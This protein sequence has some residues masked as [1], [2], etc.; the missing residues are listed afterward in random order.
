MK[1]I[2]SDEQLPDTITKTLFLAGPSIRDYKETD[3]RKNAISILEELKYD[4]IVFIPIPSPVFYGKTPLSKSSYDNQIKWEQNARRMSDVILFW[5]LR[6]L[7]KKAYGLT[8]NFELGEDLNTGKVTYGR[9][10]N[11]DKCRYTDTC[12]TEK[13]LPI[14]QC[15]N[16]LIKYSLTFLFN[17]KRE[18]GE[19][20][21]QSSL[22]KNHNFVNWLQLNKKVGNYLEDAKVITVFP[23]IL[24]IDIFSYIIQVNVFIKNENRY[25]SN[26]IILS[27]KDLTSVLPY[28]KKDGQTYIVLVKEYRT[29]V[30]NADNYVYELPGGSGNGL[31]NA[32]KELVE[33]TNLNIEQSRFQFVNTRQVSST[34]SVHTNSIYRVELNEEEINYILNVAKNNIVFEDE[35]GCERTFIEILNIN[36]LF[37]KPIDYGNLGAIFECFNGVNK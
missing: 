22:W 27:R 17:V 12:V 29:P 20:F 14:F 9:P 4:G 6:D 16:E 35:E 15:L 25:K 21:I 3:W 30:R 10:D 8:T 11:A 31:E 7:D 19:R 34:F 33:E 2:F 5:I 37:N 24:G 1:I 28:F 18:N 23:S 13:G 32:Q 36:N 26:E